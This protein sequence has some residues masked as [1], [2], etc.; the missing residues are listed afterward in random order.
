M[1]G[2]VWESWGFYL[3]QLDSLHIQGA[4]HRMK[5]IHTPVGVVIRLAILQLYDFRGNS[6]VA[7]ASHEA[8]KAENLGEVHCWPL[9]V[10]A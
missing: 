3:G 4:S 5:R 10:R 9:E 2:C 7:D 6:G 8:E 1:P